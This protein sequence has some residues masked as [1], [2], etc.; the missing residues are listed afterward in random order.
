[1]AWRLPVV[2]LLAVIG[3]VLSSLLALE[4]HGFGPAAAA[5]S[6]L[7]GAG[8]DAGCAAVARSGYAS[9]LGVPL[10]ALGALFYASTGLLAALGQFSVTPARRAA[11]RLLLAAFAAALVLDVGLFG[12]Q[13][14]VIHAWCKLCLATYVV[15]LLCAATLWPAFTDKAAL[16]E[17]REAPDGRG[18]FSM[19]TP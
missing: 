2:L 1:M 14:F 13:A 19:R 4:Y 16:A 6:A 18:R 8:E 15:N 9:I 7:C 12:L 11:E 17:G 3:F 5:V 10:G